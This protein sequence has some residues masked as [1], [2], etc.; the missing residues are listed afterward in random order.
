MLFLYFIADTALL[1]ASRSLT[2]G[3]LVRV[4][5]G[6]FFFQQYCLSI[7]LGIQKLLSIMTVMG[8]V[9]LRYHSVL[10]SGFYR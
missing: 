8:I 5:M 7:L 1:Q 10:T 6:H 3:V 4:L 2:H 9:K